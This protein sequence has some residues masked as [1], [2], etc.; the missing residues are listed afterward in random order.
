MYLSIS[1]LCISLSLWLWGIIP[2]DMFFEPTSIIQYLEPL[3][4]HE[5]T[6]QVIK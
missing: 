4:V 2:L 1:I 6:Q 5:Y 3:P